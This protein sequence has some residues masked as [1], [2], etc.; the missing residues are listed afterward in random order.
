M[1]DRTADGQLDGTGDNELDGTA[2]AAL[3]GTADTELDEH[4]STR[5]NTTT[6]KRRAA[7]EP[8]TR[9]HEARAENKNREP[10]IHEQRI[11]SQEPG[12][13]KQEPEPG[14]EN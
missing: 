7:N 14:T 1:L 4:E 9:K 11:R 6:I 12:T 13:R 8:E 3:D 5:T 10:G 2:G